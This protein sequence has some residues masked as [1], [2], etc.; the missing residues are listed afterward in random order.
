MRC[1]YKEPEQRFVSL[2]C[3]VVAMRDRQERFSEAYLAREKS[4]KDTRITRDNSEEDEHLQ[5]NVIIKSSRQLEREQV[6]KEDRLTLTSKKDISFL[7][8]E[9]SR[10][11]KDVY[12]V[13][14]KNV[15]Q[16]QPSKPLVKQEVLAEVP[17]PLVVSQPFPHPEAP[18]FRDLLPWAAKGAYFIMHDKNG[19][20][21]AAYRY[22][23]KNC[24]GIY[25]HESKDE[26]NS[27]SEREPVIVMDLS[28]Y[29]IL[30]QEEE[31]G[32]TLRRYYPEYHACVCPYNKYML[33]GEGVVREHYVLNR[34]YFYLTGLNLDTDVETCFRYTKLLA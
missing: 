9:L 6:E 4:A 5:R 12:M 11:A 14:K 28:H 17:L 18:L 15:S 25:A 8:S 16:Q 20:N 10:P 31:W 30:M 24:G 19:K 32:A 23:H 26:M 22:F 27:A 34:P 1:P 29:P 2:A 7:P 3:P 21:G 33:R 13:A